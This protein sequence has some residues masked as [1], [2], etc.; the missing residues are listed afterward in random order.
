[1]VNVRVAAP[2]KYGGGRVDFAVGPCRGGFQIRI[3][4][5]SATALYETDQFGA[6]IGI[7]SLD[8][9]PLKGA[10]GVD[11]PPGMNDGV[12][13]PTTAVELDIIANGRR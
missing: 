12:V 2:N 6:S 13:R 8:I 7:F 4:R 5:N 9:R 11:D 10:D 3:A 1:V